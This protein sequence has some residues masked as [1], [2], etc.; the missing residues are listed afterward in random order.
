MSCQLY[1]SG[2]GALPVKVVAAFAGVH[3]E[4]APFTAGITE[5]TAAFRELSPDGQVSIYTSLHL[6][7]VLLAPAS[8]ASGVS[9]PQCCLVRAR[10]TFAASSPVQLRAACRVKCHKAYASMIIYSTR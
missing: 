3:L 1:G 5:R 4:E 8:D 2:L 9:V 10:H 7:C 6:C